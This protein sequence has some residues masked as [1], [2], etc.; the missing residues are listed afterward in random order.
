MERRNAQ[1]LLLAVQMSRE[2]RLSSLEC[3]GYSSLPWIHAV[4]HAK[5]YSRLMLSSIKIRFLVKL[6][7]GTFVTS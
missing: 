5:R 4:A 7:F 2:L 1:L 6:A 3:P